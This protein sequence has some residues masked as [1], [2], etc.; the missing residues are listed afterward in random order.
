M[1]NYREVDTVNSIC[2]ALDVIE[3]GLYESKRNYLQ[4]L[5][6]KPDGPVWEDAMGE[7]EWYIDKMYRPFVDMGKRIV[8]LEETVEKQQEQI[9]ELMDHI[10]GLYGA[11]DEKE[12]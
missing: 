8:E 2:K 12:D 11:D 1:K 3:S 4:S 10:A 7:L 6:Y 9:N 5:G